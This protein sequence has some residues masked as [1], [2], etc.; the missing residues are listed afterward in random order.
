MKTCSKCKQTK[1]FTKFTTRSASRDGLDYRCKACKNVAS[2]RWVQNN[3][4]KVHASQKKYRGKP[5][6]K[7]RFNAQRRKRRKTDTNF[8]L[9]RNLRSRLRKALK[10]KNKSAST[11]ALL[12]CSIS[13]LK[14]YLEKQF[15]PGM[16]WENHGKWHADHM[17]PCASFD[18]TDPEQQRRSFHY[19]NLQP[20]WGPE[21]CSKS[22]KVIYNREWNG[23]NWVWS[24]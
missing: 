8:R 15:Q 13:H 1:A 24:I 11:I 14:K 9:L 17:I 12:G 5:E 16:T 20:M 2:L 22:D 18:F 3:R 6:I 21:N 4:D 7:K 19:T 23:S 10:G